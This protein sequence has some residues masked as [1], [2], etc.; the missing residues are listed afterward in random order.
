MSGEPRKALFKEVLT[1]FRQR[2]T[3]NGRVVWVS[4]GDDSV[5]TS[6]DALNDLGVNAASVRSLPSVVIYDNLQGRLVL[7]DIGK[8]R[9]LMTAHRRDALTRLFRGSKAELIFVNVF[10]GRREFQKLLGEPLWGT[11]VWL[12]DEPDHVIHFNGNRFLSVH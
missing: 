6:V 9:G 7:I 11:T 2:F 4:E 3:P 12:A 5:F 10:R 1:A 8:R